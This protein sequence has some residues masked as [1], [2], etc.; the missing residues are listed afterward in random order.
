MIETPEESGGLVE[1]LC[2]TCKRFN[3]KDLTCEAFPEG[4]PTII[5]MGIYDHR[6]EYSMGGVSDNFL[7][8]DPVDT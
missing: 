1:S 7:T 2:Y 8:Y 3:R 4:I 6:N 5:L